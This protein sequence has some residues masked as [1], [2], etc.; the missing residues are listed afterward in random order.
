MTHLDGIYGSPGQ[1]FHLNDYEGRPDR[2]ALTLIDDD[3]VT[4]PE[5]REA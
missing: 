4:A 2:P 3:V 5:G 1:R